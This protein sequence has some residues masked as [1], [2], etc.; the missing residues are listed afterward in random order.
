MLRLK[1]GKRGVWFSFLND[2]KYYLFANI[3]IMFIIYSKERKTAVT[4]THNTE[5]NYLYTRF[6]SYTNTFT[7]EKKT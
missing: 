4:H 3:I 5:I 2:F 7:Q 1:R 6:L